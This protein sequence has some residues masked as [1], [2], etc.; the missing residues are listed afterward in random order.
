[1]HLD[2]AGHPLHT[3]A[4]SI[5]LFQ[6]GD[7]RL[8]ARGTLVDLRKRSFVPVGGDLQGPGV[9]HHMQLDAVLDPATAT[10]D[11]IAASQPAVA[12][13]PSPLTAGESCRDPVD[14]IRA[15]AGTPLDSTF[16]TGVSAAVGG[17]RGCSHILTLAHL[18]GST[19]AWALARERVGAGAGAVRPAGQRVFCR[20]LIV[21]GQELRPGRVQLAAQ[22]TDLHFAPAPLVARPMDRFAGELEVRVLAEVDLETFALVG[23]RAAERRR[24]PADFVTAAWAPRDDVLAPLAG[25]S[26]GA[27]ITAALLAH[28]GDRPADRP[29]LDALLLLSPTLIQCMATLTDTWPAAALRSTSSVGIGGLPDSC[30]MWRRGGALARAQEADATTRRSRST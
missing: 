24:G 29:L 7:G 13:D 20:N 21:D 11:T 28:L 17:P 18:L 12:F 3:R 27:G 4:L 10:L 30:Y 23:V 25:R 15:L 16:A 6:R 22:L 19:A 8:D 1:M 14:R 5:A 9:I 26:M 2:A